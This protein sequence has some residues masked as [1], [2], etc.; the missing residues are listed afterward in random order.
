VVEAAEGSGSLIT[1]RDAL[2]Q[3]REV[4]AVPGHPMD[5]R[6]GG[7][8]LLIR[9]GAR[10][11]RSVEDV[12]EALG[13]AVPPRISQAAATRRVAPTG[14]EG[15]RVA[16]QD[17]PDA[18]KPGGAVIVESW[19]PKAS[20]VRSP[21]G[22]QRDQ[23]RAPVIYPPGSDTGQGGGEVGPTYAPSD[24]QPVPKAYSVDRSGAA[25]GHLPSP[26]PLP[27]GHRAQP[28]MADPARLHVLILSALGPSPVAEDQLL[29]D[30]ALPASQAA[31]ALLFLELAGRIRR[32]PGG[33][34]ALA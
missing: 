1:A 18:P 29:R 19:A 11:I 28:A 34:L 27:Q 3:G 33:M 15:R 22:Q 31:P 25:V 30:L 26:A 21:E 8:N 24:P 32:A 5:A 10:L 17:A 20:P 13:P 12:I 4:L 6:A 9:E 23:T 14:A 2:E 7:C 16:P